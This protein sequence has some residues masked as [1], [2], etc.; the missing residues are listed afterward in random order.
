[1]TLGRSQGRDASAA[2]FPDCHTA[3]APPHLLRW[4]KRLSV[5]RY[6][7]LFERLVQMGPAE[8]G[9]RLWRPARKGLRV[10]CR[11]YGLAWGTSQQCREAFLQGLGAHPE[12]RIAARLDRHFFFGPS[13]RATICEQ[14]QEQAP[15]VVHRMRGAADALRQSGITL[16]GQRVRLIPGEIDW[17]ADPFTQQR[18]WSSGVLDESEA[19]HT[20]TADVKYVW[21]IN[22]HQYL[23]TLGRAFWLTG[24][25]RYARDAV[26]LVQDWLVQNPV[27]LGVNWCS[28][29]EVAVRAISWL[30]TLP[31]VMTW[32]GLDDAVLKGWLGSLAEH[33]H[34]LCGHL[35]VYTDPTNHLIGEA[36]A[37]WML[38]LVFPELPGAQH[39]H[40][41]ARDVLLREAERQVISDG[42]NAEQATSYHRFVLDF[43]LQFYILAQRAGEVLPR[44][45]AERLEAMLGFASALAGAYGVAPMIGDSD[46]AR[47]VPF[48]DGIGWDFRDVLS[49]GAVLFQRPDWKRTSGGLSEITVWL[50]GVEAIGQYDALGTA[51]SMDGSQVFA[52]GGYGFL[53]ASQPQ[54]DVELIFDVGPLG[55]M[56]HAAHGHADALSVLVRIN[57]RFL[58]T[59]PGTGAYFH[60]ALVRD[61]FRRTA[62]HNTV[63][64]DGLDQ[65]DLLDTFKWVNP[66]VVR[67]QAS[68]LSERFDYLRA[69]HHGYHRLRDAVTHERT[70]LFVRPDEWL[71]VD[72]LEGRGHHAFAQHFHFAPDV[73]I[74]R[75][76]PHEVVAF[77]SVSGI[78]LQLMFAH[79]TADGPAVLRL[80]DDGGWSGSYGHW[81][82]APRVQIDVATQTPQTFLTFVRPVTRLN[83]SG[84][85]TPV[86]S[87][88]HAE[89]FAE[90]F[91]SGRA[92]LYRRV[93][94]SI[95]TWVLVNPSQVPVELPR[96]WRSNAAFL[97]LEIRLGDDAI[98]RVFMTGEGSTFACG[99][100]NL[101]CTAAEPFIGFEL[102]SAI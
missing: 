44:A 54:A 38:T 36:A 32:D 77:D 82:P 20:R 74:E 73:R 63:T 45:L 10:L 50:L 12:A 37:L 98:E 94:P 31:Y 72:R 22:R 91:D 78:G 102:V 62:T 56:P 2:P 83:T 1:M 33:Y 49:T 90:K 84:G 16:L 14:L 5:R 17:Q 9:T 92:I 93:Q 21:E 57:G 40:Q 100:V 75:R 79:A 24:E 87:R 41:R 89:I 27:G 58:L 43:Y 46:D 65:A 15:D 55:L 88:C 52:K 95:E 23:P 13:H 48:V 80:D 3:S 39:Q 25:D 51:A 96:G 101:A 53:R 4:R 6:V 47:G 97:Y 99:K 26:A 76:A 68:Y 35:S 18:M 85:A 29:L 86:A 8:I 66:M 7:R 67:L 19:V 81:E 59:D 28:H 42:V 34:H 30:W 71:V 60:S 70:V 69:V 64:V 61:V 11:R